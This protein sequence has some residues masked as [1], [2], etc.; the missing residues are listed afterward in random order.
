M[1]LSRI[2]KEPREPRDIRSEQIP[3]R[4]SKKERETVE[5]VAAMEHDYA[6]SFLRRMILKQ[7]GFAERSNGKEVLQG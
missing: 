3:I 1:K 4:F 2:V 6:S 5:R 7:I